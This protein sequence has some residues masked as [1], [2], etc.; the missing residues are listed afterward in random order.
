MER[1]DGLVFIGE[2]F[3][4]LDTGSLMTLREASPQARGHFTRFD[5]VNQLV[6]VSEADANLGFMARLIVLCSLRPPLYRVPWG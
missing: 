6:G 1:K 4:D 5:Q 2:A 3:S